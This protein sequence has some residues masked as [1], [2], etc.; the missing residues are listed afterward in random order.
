MYRVTLF[1]LVN[2]YYLLYF[3]SFSAV[4]LCVTK[5]SI[6]IISSSIKT[7][8]MILYLIMK[9]GWLVIRQRIFDRVLICLC[10]VIKF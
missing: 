7:E 5:F 3:C 8:V 2:I 1:S 6:K 9:Y 4:N 10:L